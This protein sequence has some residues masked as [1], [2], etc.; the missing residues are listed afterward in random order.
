MTPLRCTTRGCLIN[1]CKSSAVMFDWKW[2]LIRLVLRVRTNLMNFSNPK[3]YLIHIFLFIYINAIWAQPRIPY[4]LRG[5]P[6]KLGATK[7]SRRRARVEDAMHEFLRKHVQCTKIPHPARKLYIQQGGYTYSKKTYLA[8]T[9]HRTVE[10]IEDAGQKTMAWVVNSPCKIR[11]RQQ[12]YIHIEKIE[13]CFCRGSH[14]DCV[15]DDERW[16]QGK[17]TYQAKVAQIED[18][19]AEL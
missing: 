2:L 11:R 8:K 17:Q 18:G 12:V 19:S 3:R 5:F 10:D 16:S 4:N 9:A 15:S 6:R 13:L 14:S 7:P 1:V